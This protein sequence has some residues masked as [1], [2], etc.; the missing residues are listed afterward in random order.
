MTERAA[1]LADLVETGESP[2]HGTGVFARTAI[3]AGTHIGSYDGDP[4]EVDDTFVLWIEDDEGDA[5]HGIDGTGLLRYLNHSQSPNAEFDGPELFAIRDIAAG[6]EL[7]FDYG[8][9]WAH[10][11]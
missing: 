5:W 10:V 11:P 1:A 4:T 6:E 7:L 9:E 8:D 3:A 2:V